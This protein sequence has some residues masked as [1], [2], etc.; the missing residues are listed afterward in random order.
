[1]LRRSDVQCADLEG[2]SRASRPSLTARDE[3][4]ESRVARLTAERPLP[5]YPRAGMPT[6]R[7]SRPHLSRK[8]LSAALC[9][10]RARA[11]SGRQSVDQRDDER[12]D[13]G[14][15][16]RV[17]DAKG[18]SCRLS[19]LALLPFLQPGAEQRDL[20]LGKI[21]EARPVSRLEH[22]GDGLVELFIVELGRKPGGAHP[23]HPLRSHASPASP[24]SRCPNRLQ[25]WSE[26]LAVVSIERQKVSLGGGQC[27][28]HSP[29]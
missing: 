13:R 3:F 27:H 23:A 18:S 5:S 2:P 8:R 11:A 12:N 7:A 21:V 26:L 19:L 25:L 22:L 4:G 6:R 24:R 15:E 14:C 10:V 16:C 9:V 28:G 29:I 1:M 17:R 20:Q